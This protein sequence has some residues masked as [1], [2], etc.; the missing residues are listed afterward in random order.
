[1]HPTREEG[2]AGSKERIWEELGQLFDHFPKYRMKILLGEF[3]AKLGREDIFK[4]TIGNESPHQD[5]NDNGIR[6]VNVGTSESLV[7]KDTMF[8]QQNFHQ[9]TWT[10]PDGK[11]HNQ[12]YHLLIDRRW[13]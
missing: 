6:I 13:N 11:T 10:F 7:F 8:P 9:H 2:S 3:N 12:I 4:P 5:S 1:M